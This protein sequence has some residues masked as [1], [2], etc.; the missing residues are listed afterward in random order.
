MNKAVD[1]ARHDAVFGKPLRDAKTRADWWLSQLMKHRHLSKDDPQRISFL[2][3]AAAF[4]RA[5]E[6]HQLAASR[7]AASR[8]YLG[9]PSE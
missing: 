5:A 2:K 1:A 8:R 9:L 4:D 3:T 6:D 7:E